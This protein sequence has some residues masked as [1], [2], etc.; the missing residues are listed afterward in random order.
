[1][2]KKLVECALEDEQ[3]WAFQQIADHLRIRQSLSLKLE[4]GT[5]PLGHRKR[6]PLRVLARRPEGDVRNTNR[7][8]PN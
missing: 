2:A 7:A 5:R 1:V 3:G 4:F 6:E 8:R